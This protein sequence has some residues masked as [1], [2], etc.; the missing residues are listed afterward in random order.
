M[1]RLAQALTSFCLTMVLIAPLAVGTEGKAPVKV[2]PKAVLTYATPSGKHLRFLVVVSF[3]VPAADSPAGA[4]KG[5]VKLTEKVKRAHKA[6]HWTAALAPKGDRC[7]AEI[8]G[9]L[10]VSLLSHYVVFKLAFPGNGL[11]GA[12]L[13]SK[14]LKLSKPESP[15]AGGSPGPGSPAP[16]TELPTIPSEP[17]TL[18]DGA[19]KGG[20]AEGN[21]QFEV[22]K[23][24]IQQLSTFSSVLITCEKKDSIPELTHRYTLF[25]Y[26]KDIPLGPA[27]EFLDNY[28]DVFADSSS[29]GQIPWVVHGNLGAS[30]GT[31]ILE[32]HDGYFNEHFPEQPEYTISECHLS[33]TFEVGKY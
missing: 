11:V 31:L 15:Q 3:P 7:D 27:G 28:T 16:V 26:K 25:R 18:A 13:A 20:A 33:I 12:F 6:P 30:S 5:K 10:P 19:W 8:K 29:D 22:N 14:K 17:Y 1:A 24:V 23:G 4:C 32:G 21:I 2:H 9:R